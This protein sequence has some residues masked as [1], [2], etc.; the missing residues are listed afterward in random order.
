V[1]FAARLLLHC[2]ERTNVSSAP[3]EWKAV[4]EAVEASISIPSLG[5]S[6]MAGTFGHEKT[7]RKLSETIYAMSWAH[8]FNQ[9]APC[10]QLTTGFSCRCQVE[11]ME[12]LIFVTRSRP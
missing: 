8:K 3:D 2:T 6:G 11:K 4:F 9:T 1:P 10:E 12:G 5:C 7:N